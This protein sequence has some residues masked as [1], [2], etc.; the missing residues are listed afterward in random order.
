VLLLG[1]GRLAEAVSE[2]RTAVRLEPRAFRGHYNLGV[3]LARQ[4]DHAGAIASYRAALALQPDDAGVHYG[5]AFSLEATGA[6]EAARAQYRAVVRLKPRYLD[7][8][9]RLARLERTGPPP[10]PP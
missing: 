5:L 4:G 3:A 8:A 7:A 6:T 2:L 9:A 1:E 10:E